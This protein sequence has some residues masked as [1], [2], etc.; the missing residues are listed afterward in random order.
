MIK[1]VDGGAAA[2][3]ARNPDH[4]AVV[5]ADAPHTVYFRNTSTLEDASVVLHEA[6]HVS[7]LVNDQDGGF[8]AADSELSRAVGGRNFSEAIN[9]A[10][11]DPEP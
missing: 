9:T 2:Y 3:F 10:C 5:F 4:D 6:F 8:F 11:P 1:T 7:T